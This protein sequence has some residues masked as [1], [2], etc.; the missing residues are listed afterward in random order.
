M[1]WRLS[2]LKRDHSHKVEELRSKRTLRWIAKLCGNRSKLRLKLFL[3]P[4][5][6]KPSRGIYLPAR[7]RLPVILHQLLHSTGL[8]RGTV[9]A[10]VLPKWIDK[11]LDRKALSVGK[12]SC[13][14]L[15]F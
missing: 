11:R 8:L 2:W 14:A 7:Y 15:T 4:G 12:W 10:F 5:I 1:D 13:N 9:N 3:A 6:S